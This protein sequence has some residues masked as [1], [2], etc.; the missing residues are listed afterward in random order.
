VTR[1]PHGLRLRA[2]PAPRLLSFVIPVFDEREGLPFLRESLESFLA[3]IEVA[4]E[5]I[6]VDDGSRDDSWAFITEWAA[7]DPRVRGLALSKNFGHQVAVT[8]GLAASGG[9]A[10]VVL[11][12]DLQDPLDV[13]PAMLKRYRE[14]YDVVYGRRT[15]RDGE[16]RFKRFTAWLFYRVMRAL[17]HR[18]LPPDTGDFRL[19]SRRCLDVVLRMNETHRFL[20]GL[21]AWVGFQQTEVAYRREARRYGITKYPLWKMVRLA[22]NAALSFSTLPVKLI[23]TMGFATALFALGYGGYAVIEKYAFHATV[24]GWTALAVLNGLIG[25]ANLLG[26][27][28]IGEYVGRVFEEAKGRPLY[29]VLE[30]TAETSSSATDGPPPGT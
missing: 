12:A 25:A 8:A 17:V 23:T 26:L 9:D 16:T 18:D 29:V 4:C 6:L 7:A 2:R 3:S 1:G 11:D 15:A 27:G 10:V 30:D 19:V 13:I 5:L 28:V 14:G 24:P 21:F 20:R 22:W